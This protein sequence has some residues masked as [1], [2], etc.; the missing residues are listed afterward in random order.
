[1]AS[2]YHQWPTPK[3]LPLLTQ[4][5]LLV[6]LADI[7]LGP[8]QA[9]MLWILLTDDEKQKAQR[10]YFPTDRD[11][12]ICARAQLRLLLGRYLGIGPAHVPIL[13]GQYGK[14][15]LPRNIATRFY[16]N[17]SHSAGL[18]LYALHRGGE[19]GVDIEYLRVDTPFNEMASRF[20]APEE[21]ASLC[22]LPQDI[23]MQAFF[24]A[25][26]RKEACVKAMGDGLHIG[27]SDFAVTLAP[28]E[29][30]RLLYSNDK[31]LAPERWHL[32]ALNVLPG[33]AAAVALAGDDCIPSCWR[34]PVEWCSLTN[35]SEK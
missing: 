13:Y 5:G 28:D 9:Q 17:V 34:Y 24:N 14:P 22:M 18:A 29:P 35:L 11:R 30:A 8:E 32:H 15:Y 26:A 6:W 19:V 4:G 7:D 25:W 27:L 2:A 12:F 1:M 21:Y 3:E 23:R 33:Y 31:R 16:F 20:F 10:Y